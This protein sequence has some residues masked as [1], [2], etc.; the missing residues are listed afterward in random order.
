[1][2]SQ[3]LLIAIAL[4]LGLSASV[5]QSSEALTRRHEHH[6]MLLLAKD[7]PLQQFEHWV[8]KHGKAYSQDP[9][10]FA[11]RLEIW[12]ENLEF[13]L[14]YNKRNTGVWLGLNSLADLSH[15]EYRARYLGF[16]NKARKQRPQR[17]ASSFK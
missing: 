2:L 7:Q 6:Q 9:V 15:D 14:D 12:L 4:P 17:L 5:V 13:V 1:M 3:L 11:N 8:A 10:E 16:N